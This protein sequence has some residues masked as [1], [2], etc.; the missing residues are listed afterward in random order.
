MESLLR[1]QHPRHGLVLPSEFIALAEQ[2]GL[3]PQIGRRVLLKACQRAARW[4]ARAS[5]PL[6]VSVNVSVRQV[7]T[8]GFVSAV[9][10]ALEIAD[11]PPHCLKLE[12]TENVAAEERKVLD[13]LAELRNW[14]VQVVIDDFGTGYSSFSSL[15]KN[16]IDCVKIDRSFVAGIP[17]DPDSAAIVRA[18]LSLARSFG[19]VVVAEGIENGRQLDFLVEHGCTQGQGFLLHRPAPASQL[20]DLVEARRILSPD[21]VGSVD[22]PPASAPRE[23]RTMGDRGGAGSAPIEPVERDSIA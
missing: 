20:D 6:P 4:Q 10:N 13:D 3:L 7:Q 19:V 16:R 11:L 2:A 18:I 5:A 17:D 21:A 9:A 23:D 14:G 12:I 15:L 22:V 8:G 1:W